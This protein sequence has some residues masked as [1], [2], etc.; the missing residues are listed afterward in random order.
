LQI[1]GEIVY[2][3]G[4]QVRDRFGAVGKPAP[5]G[6]LGAVRANISRG[7]DGPA[8]GRGRPQALWLF[9]T[10][11]CGVYDIENLDITRSESQA[12]AGEIELSSKG[13]LKVASGSALLLRV[14]ASDD[15]T[16]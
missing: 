9:S 15:P 1:G 5:G 10:S 6:I 8:E 16:T 4:G 12:P 3:G 2:R 11:A 13:Q 14:I 7:C